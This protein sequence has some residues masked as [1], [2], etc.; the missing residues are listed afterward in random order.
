M[1]ENYFKILDVGQNV[2]KFLP[3]R[4]TEMS[5]N[6]PKIVKMSENAYFDELFRIF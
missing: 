4:S 3:R 1:S 6:E 2:G 5:E